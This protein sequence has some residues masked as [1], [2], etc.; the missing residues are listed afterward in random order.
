MPY[1]VN[2]KQDPH[3]YSATDSREYVIDSYSVERSVSI[4]CRKY[5]KD[6]RKARGQSRAV[7]TELIIHA[8]LI[9]GAKM[10]GVGDVD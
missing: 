9:K 8:Q 5:R 10:R 4:A 7:I 2:I 1:R 3:R 6:V